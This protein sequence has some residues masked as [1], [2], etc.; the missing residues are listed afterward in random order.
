[1]KRKL[2]QLAALSAT[3]LTAVYVHG[4]GDLRQHILCGEG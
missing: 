1:M 3:M 4:P 2:T